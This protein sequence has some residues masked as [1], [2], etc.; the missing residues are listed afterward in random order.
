[1]KSLLNRSNPATE[2]ETAPPPTVPCSANPRRLSRRIRLGLAAGDLM[3]V[4]L[5]L[6]LV[7]TPTGLPGGW[8]VPLAGLAVTLAA[9]LGY[10][11]V[12]GEG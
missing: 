8:A 7:F 9:W 4:A 3:L 12:C 5:A 2:A 10:L 11:A 6:V 1:M